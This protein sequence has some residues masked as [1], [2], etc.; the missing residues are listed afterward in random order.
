VIN[1]NICQCKQRLHP[2]FPVLISALGCQKFD[3]LALFLPSLFLISFPAVTFSPA[4]T[5][6]QLDHQD[7]FLECHA[8]PS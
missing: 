1:K 3:L 7:A 2:F 4:V 8:G 5:K 6:M